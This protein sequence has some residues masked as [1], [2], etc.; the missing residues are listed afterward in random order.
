VFRSNFTDLGRDLAKLHRILA[1]LLMA[2]QQRFNKKRAD[3]FLDSAQR[4]RE[5]TRRLIIFE[6]ASV[7]IYLDLENLIRSGIR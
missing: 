5:K 6:Q 3:S 2:G 4:A 7:T 1:G